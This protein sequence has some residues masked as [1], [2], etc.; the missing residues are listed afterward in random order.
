M[1]GRSLNVTLPPDLAEMVEGKVA[2]GAYASESEVVSAGLRALQRQERNEAGS[3][4]W[5]LWRVAD[6]LA[7]QR[8]SRP[9]E[10]VFGRLRSR[11][12]GG[13]KHAGNTWP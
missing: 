13:T 10:E 5:L 9:G 2:S 3:E 1:L 7:D 12:A 11:L 8:P 6:S 4:E